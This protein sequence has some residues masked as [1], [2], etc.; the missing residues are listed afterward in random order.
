M[1]DITITL[2]G[3]PPNGTYT[4]SSNKVQSDGTIRVKPGTTSIRFARGAGQPWGTSSL[5]DG[6]PAS[7]PGCTSPVP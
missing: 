2:T 1:P 3:T 7:R 6:W 5:S 4:S